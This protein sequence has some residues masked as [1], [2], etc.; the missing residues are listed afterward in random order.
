MIKC[1][2]IRESSTGKRE[3]SREWEVTTEG[4]VFPC[5]FFVNSYTNYTDNKEMQGGEVLLWK[6]DDILRKKFE[7]DPDWNNINVRDFDDIIQDEIYWNYIYYPGWESN[8]P[9]LICDEECNDRALV[10]KLNKDD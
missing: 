10:V 6:H 4:R 1:M 9:P 3:E 5:C 2:A 7:Q 8:D